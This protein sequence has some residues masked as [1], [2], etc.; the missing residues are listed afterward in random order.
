MESIG[1]LCY[2]LILDGSNEKMDAKGKRCVFLGYLMNK[3]GYKLYDIENKRVFVSRD[4][5]FKEH[6]FH[7]K[8]QV[9]EFESSSKSLSVF[10]FITPSKTCPNS[11]QYGQVGS[12]LVSF[13]LSAIQPSS[14]LQ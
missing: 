14:E 9:F 5:I 4:V 3:K 12:F 11:N 1:C 8:S 6:V 10:S 7:F 2:V 13:T